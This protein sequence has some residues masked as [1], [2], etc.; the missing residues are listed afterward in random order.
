MGVSAPEIAGELEGMGETRDADGK[1]GRG[2]R[3]FAE[4]RDQPVIAPAAADRA[5]DDFLALFVGDG[6]GQF[7]LEDG[8]GV[9]FE[10]ADDGGVDLDAVR[11]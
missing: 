10:A 8:A 4:A 3:L 7:D 5:E 9:I 11:P 1:A 6:E 2:H